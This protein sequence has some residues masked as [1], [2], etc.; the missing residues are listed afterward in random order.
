[1]PDREAAEREGR[2][3][4]AEAIA[5]HGSE[6]V[7][8]GKV[9]RLEA[10][11][12]LVVERNDELLSAAVVR[13]GGKVVAA[14]GDHVNLW[15][16]MAGDHS[17]HAQVRVPIWS[18]GARWGQVELRF[19]QSGPDGWVGW[20][21]GPR[22]RLVAFMALVCFGAFYFYLRRMLAHLDPSQAVPTHV[23]SALDTLAEGLLV[24]DLRGRIVLANQAF[25]ALVGRSGEAL[26]GQDAGEL[27]WAEA[28]ALPSRPSSRGCARSSWAHRCATSSSTSTTRAA[29]C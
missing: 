20:I 22:N 14:F 19:R 15:E 21:F 7:T 1:M 4:I 16:P 10:A 11:L 23:R 17:T 5:I 25:S 2:A 8:H 3:A 28:T 9:D 27:E 13:T 12:E 6:L 29:S 26:I 18:A 24:V